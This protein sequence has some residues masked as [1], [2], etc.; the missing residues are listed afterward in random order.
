MCQSIDFFSSSIKLNKCQNELT[1][2]LMCVK[3]H[4][5]HSTND[6]EVKKTSEKK[7]AIVDTLIE[8][9]I[10]VS[11]EFIGIA[12][13]HF[14]FV[15]YKHF[16]PIPLITWITINCSEIVYVSDVCKNCLTS[17]SIDSLF[18]MAINGNI[19]FFIIKCKFGN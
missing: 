3:W 13:V 5:L 19:F 14:S 9:F 11:N 6:S 10:F 15:A 8:R 1:H 12:F 7:E 18:I 4:Q 2:P 16:I 17:N